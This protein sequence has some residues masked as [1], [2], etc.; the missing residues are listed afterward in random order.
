MTRHAT[1]SR[2]LVGRH[3]K[4]GERS[5]VEAGLRGLNKDDGER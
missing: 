2:P 5:D 3:R 4:A 1:D